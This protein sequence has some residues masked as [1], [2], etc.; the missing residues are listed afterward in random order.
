MSSDPRTPDG[1]PRGRMDRHLS[2]LLTADRLKHVL[3]NNRVHDGSRLENSAEHSWHLA[4]MALTLAEHAPAGTD[5]GRVVEMLVLH[6]VVEIEAGDHWMPEHDPADVA[7]R[8][9]DAAERLFGLLPEELRDRFHALWVE[10]EAQAT[11]E[12]R[13]AR[14]L[15]SLHPM[16]MVWGPGGSDQVHIDVT[17]GFMREYK[18]A[19]LESYP[20]IWRM[21]QDL[22]DGAVSRGTLPP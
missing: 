8:E 2:F 1:S 3:R 13:F 19:A 18:R 21:A 5:I 6:D 17:A 20:E 16:L 4:L 7:A 14:A 22:L 15:D 11:E 12:A 9:A 10:Y